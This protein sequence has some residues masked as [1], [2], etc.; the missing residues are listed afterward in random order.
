MTK[1]GLLTKFDHL[2]AIAKC[3]TIM[4]A[5]LLLTANATFSSPQI[6]YG[7]VDG[8][9]QGTDACNPDEVF[10][11]M[12]QEKFLIPP[13]DLNVRGIAVRVPFK[14]KENREVGTHG[15]TRNDGTKFHA[16]TDLIGDEGESVV[17]VTGGK[18]IAA[19]FSPTLG[20]YAILRTDVVIPP[21]LPCAVDFVYAHLKSLAKTGEVVGGSK[22]GEM[23]RTGNLESN[24]P[25]HLHIEIWAGAYAPGLKARKM[26]TRD[27][28][29]LFRLF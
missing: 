16:G 1:I 14:A 13:V 24:I 8:V 19:G 28:I 20:N 18:V 9:N 26:L 6:D 11:K 21:A 17:A 10:A 29:V 25:T 12:K 7:N 23:G 3:T 22:I 27:I 2:H 5:I 4:F 15:F